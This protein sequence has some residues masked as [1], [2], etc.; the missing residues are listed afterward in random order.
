MSSLEGSFRLQR[1]KRLACAVY[2]GGE[3]E[4]RSMSE[5]GPCTSSMAKVMIA[6]KYFSGPFLLLMLENSASYVILQAPG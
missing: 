3:E 1:Y 6:T 2:P 5:S 4:E